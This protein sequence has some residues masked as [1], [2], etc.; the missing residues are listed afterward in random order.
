MF[1]GFVRRNVYLSGAM[2]RGQKYK[3][4]CFSQAR[5]NFVLFLLKKGK[6]RV[7]FFTK[8]EGCIL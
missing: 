6:V 4:I 1:Y 2:K 7:A 8:N 3:S 5:K